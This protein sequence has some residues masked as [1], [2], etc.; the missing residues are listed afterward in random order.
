MST[1]KQTSSVSEQLSG[2][3]NKKEAHLCLC[4]CGSLMEEGVMI[5][6]DLALQIVCYSPP[7]N[8]MT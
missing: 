7:K 4:D 1:T 6:K 8:N 2:C 5:F 3:M